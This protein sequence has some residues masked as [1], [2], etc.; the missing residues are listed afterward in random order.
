MPKR[1]DRG[2]FMSANQLIDFLIKP[3]PF[4]VFD[5]KLIRIYK[6]VD[7]LPRDFHNRPQTFCKAWMNHELLV[8]KRKTI[9]GKRQVKA[10]QA[11]KKYHETKKG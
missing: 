3:K 10:T 1:R 8:T 9:L 6:S 5:H 7:E 4:G 2:R 11:R